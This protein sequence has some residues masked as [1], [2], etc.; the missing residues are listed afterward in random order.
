MY[1]VTTLDRNQSP[2]SVL[3]FDFETEDKATEFLMT[4]RY[5]NLSIEESYSSD[6]YGYISVKDET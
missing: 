2:V 4:Y 5:N 6:L 1:Q 3:I